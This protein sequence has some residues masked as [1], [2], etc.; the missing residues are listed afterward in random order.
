MHKHDSLLINAVSYMY[1][2]LHLQ[3]VAKDIFNLGFLIGIFGKDCGDNQSEFG[4]ELFDP[5][6]HSYNHFCQA[7]CDYCP[8]FS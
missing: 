5:F 8:L 4:L 2:G 7:V 6:L 3:K 1:F